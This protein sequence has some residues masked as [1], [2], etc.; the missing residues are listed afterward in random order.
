MGIV[1]LRFTV[2]LDK[3]HPVASAVVVVVVHVRSVGLVRVKGAILTCDTV[4][5]RGGPDEGPDANG[6]DQRGS[7]EEKEEH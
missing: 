5:Q 2:I 6:H 7:I 4:E 3:G 1:L